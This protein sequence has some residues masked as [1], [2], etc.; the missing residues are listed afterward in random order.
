MEVVAGE[1]Y[2]HELWTGSGSTTVT[3]QIQDGEDVAC[4]VHSRWM[5]QPERR[6]YLTGIYEHLSDTCGR[7]FMHNVSLQQVDRPSR[8][9][10]IAE[11]PAVDVDLTALSDGLMDE[12]RDGLMYES[13][14]VIRT[15][16]LY[17]PQDDILPQMR[18]RGYARWNEYFDL[19]L[20]SAPAVIAAFEQSQRKAEPAQDA[21]TTMVQH[22]IYLVQTLDKLKLAKREES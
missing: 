15:P 10:I 19:L 13:F 17:Y 16:V 21:D 18:D 14:R 7:I 3:L 2:W 8:S 20:I 9:T 12:L 22:C 6:Y 4:T 5:G 1:T 11:V